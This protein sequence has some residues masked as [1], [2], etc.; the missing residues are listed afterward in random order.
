MTR[1]WNFFERIVAAIHLAESKGAKVTWN[2][3]VNRR[4]FDVVVRFEHGL[5]KYVTLIECKDYQRPVPL[6]EVE[7]FITK[8]RDAGANKSVMISPS[9]FQS[10]C[11]IVAKEHNIDLLRISKSVQIPEELLTADKQ[12]TIGILEV[13]LALGSTDSS[14]LRLPEDNG[15]LHYLVTHSIVTHNSE[16]R[17]LADIIMAH[18]DRNISDY[19][20][21]ETEALIHTRDSFV[22]VPDL[23]EKDTPIVAIHFVV[24]I[25]WSRVL[26]DRAWD[27]GLVN[28][29]HTVYELYDVIA[30]R[31]VTIHAL[32]LR[33]GINTVLQTGR[34]YCNPTLGKNYYCER[35]A[36]G[37]ARMWLLESYASGHLIQVNFLQS[38]KYQDQ[39][40]EVSDEQDLE[41]LRAMLQRVLRTAGGTFADS[42]N[43]G[44]KIGWA[45]FRENPRHFVGLFATQVEA[46]AQRRSHGND[47][48]VRFGSNRE[49]SDDFIPD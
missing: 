43:I 1:D 34:F 7:A 36:S 25:G 2:E 48:V 14:R 37:Q 46:E 15:R 23:C 10:G 31:R 35:V 24:K 42:T 9:G 13:E 47:Y 6:K 11:L 3:R 27:Q 41:R 22:T 21:G 4:Q 28:R 17:R 39:Y 49:D 29:L 32:G 38:T 5:Y 16:R 8:S 45:V 12:R 20:E 33:L 30:D 40:V 44:W 18:V 19:G 26:R